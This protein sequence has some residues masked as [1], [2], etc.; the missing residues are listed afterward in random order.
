M[1]LVGE[2]ELRELEGNFV[3]VVLFSFQSNSKSLCIPDFPA[4]VDH[5]TQVEVSSLFEF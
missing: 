1:I 2:S 3:L 4:Q 5:A